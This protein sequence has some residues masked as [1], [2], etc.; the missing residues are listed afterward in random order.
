MQPWYSRDCLSN[1][2]S[3]LNSTEQALIRAHRNPMHVTVWLLVICAMIYSVIAIGG[4]TRLTQSGLSMVDWRPISG[5]LPPLTQTQWIAEFEHYQQ[6]PEYKTVN[7]DLSLQGFKRIFWIEYTHR[8]A[9]RLVALAFLIPFLFFQF[10]GYFSIA[11]SLR[12]IAVFLVGGLQGLLGWYM[13]RSGMVSDPSVSQYR[14]AAH[15]SL[16]VLLYSYVLWLSIGLI[17]KK[18][19]LGYPERSRQLSAGIAICI[20]LVAIMLVS[21]G[22]M[23]GTRAGFVVNTY[24]RM[25]GEWIP[26]MLFSLT[27]LWVNLFENV[28]AIQFTHR[29]VA[30]ALVMATAIV[31]FQRFSMDRSAVR[32][33]LDIAMIVVICQF[34]L[35]VATLVSRVQLPI[36]LA[37]QSGFVMLLS[38]LIIMLRLV[39]TGLYNGTMNK[40]IGVNR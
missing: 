40:V 3:V 27:P 2:P 24:P 34:C 25:N 32:I 5:V 6:F 20:G 31:W 12:L 14:L 11:M 37:H 39:V 30:F 4:Y 36:A 19:R 28:I 8:M 33:L 18:F 21:G 23:S 16:A 35:G 17:C 38:I 1:L 29:W 13:V 26:D 22:F 7:I 10:R 9:G 15:L